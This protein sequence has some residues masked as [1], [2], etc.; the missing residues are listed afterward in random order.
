MDHSWTSTQP[1]QITQSD[2][3]EI[4]REMADKMNLCDDCSLLFDTSHDDRRHARHGWC[5]EG[6]ELLPKQQK[7]DTEKTPEKTLMIMTNV[8]KKSVLDLRPMEA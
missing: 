8:L 4:Q 3:C 5:T 7:V 1:V 6:Q 2:H